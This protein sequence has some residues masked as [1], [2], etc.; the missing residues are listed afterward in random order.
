M[1]RYNLRPNRPPPEAYSIS[2]RPWTRKHILGGQ[3]N[4]DGWR[5]AEKNRDLIAPGR[6][7]YVA[8]L[9]PPYEGAK[10]Q[11]YPDGVDEN[12]RYTFASVYP[13]LFVVMW[14][15]ETSFGACMID[16]NQ[17][18]GD[19]KALRAYNCGDEKQVWGVSVGMSDDWQWENKFRLKD[20]SVV[21]LEASVLLYDQWIWET[22]AIVKGE[23][24]LRLLL[25]CENFVERHPT[26]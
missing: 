4:S 8:L 1:H 19:F 16:Q 26:M 9:E 14:Q 24:F 17:P 25:A 10:D 12:G 11:L 20:D 6:L 23:D 15:D 18:E 21:H 22:G 3:L 7:I 13:T 2:N 5:K